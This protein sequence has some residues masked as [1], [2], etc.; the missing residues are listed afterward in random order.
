M[1][2]GAMWSFVVHE[3]EK[4][5]GDVILD[6]ENMTVASKM[7]KKQRRENVSFSVRSGEIVCIAGIDGNGQT[8]LVYGL[9]GWSRSPTA[10]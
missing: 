5:P 4:V 10:K 7:H 2:V 8:E 9:T 1:M 6:V 3:D